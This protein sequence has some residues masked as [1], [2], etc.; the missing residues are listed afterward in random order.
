[1]DPCVICLDTIDEK[2]LYT[3]EC[4]HTFHRKCIQ[5]WFQ[6]Q[7]QQ[8]NTLTCPTCRHVNGQLHHSQHSLSPNQ[9][10]RLIM[11]GILTLPLILELVYFPHESARLS[12]VLQTLR[13]QIQRFYQDQ[14]YSL[15]KL[16]ILIGTA[17]ALDRITHN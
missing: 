10:R 15:L 1:M 5:E 8:H 11:D 17:L 13:P 6:T 2:D 3:L 4:K 12:R 9:T 14:T 7:L 16:S